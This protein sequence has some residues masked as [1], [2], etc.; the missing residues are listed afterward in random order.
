MAGV[1]LPD[2][3][4]GVAL[5]GQYGGAYLPVATDEAG[6]LYIVLTGS[7]EITIPGDVNV[8]D[9][10][11]LKQI[12]GTDGTTF[13]TAKLNSNGEFIIV[14]RGASGN[15]LAVDA[16]GYMTTVM[17]AIG[18]DANLHTLK[19]DSNGQL[20]MIPRG[21]SGNYMSVDASGYLTAILKGL[22]PDASLGTITVDASG[23]LIMVPRG[24]TGNYMAVDASGFLSSIMKA[25]KGGGALVNVATDANGQLIMVPRGS[26]GNYLYVD[27]VGYLRAVMQGLY[28]ADYR[29]IHTDI[30]GNMI[31]V[32]K[33]TV[34]GHDVTI[35][36]N[37]FLTSVM[38]G[39][40]GATLKTLAVDASGNLV[41]LM[42]GDY[43][44]TLKSVAVDDQGRMISIVMD[45][46]DQWGNV[47]Q[48]GF[49]ELAARL[50]SIVSYDRR[51]QVIFADTFANGFAS[52]SRAGSSGYYITLDPSR[53]LNDGYS[54]KLYPGSVN[55][56]TATLS[57]PLTT[58]PTGTPFGLSAWLFMN[59]YPGSW[60]LW[61]RYSDGATFH[62][63]AIKGVYA[64]GNVYYL[65]AANGL[66]QFTTWKTDILVKEAF[67]FFKLVIN[68]ATH[69]YVRAIIDGNEIDMSALSYYTAAATPKYLILNI[70]VGSDG[71]NN[72]PANVDDV[73]FTTM[74][75]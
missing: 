60:V 68:P 51:G 39:I 1:E 10:N 65:N 18:I 29:S 69:K 16:S 33:D 21:T 44:G 11:T 28:G 49:A 35:D 42:K 30:S 38:K 40:Y 31:A 32:I 41:S 2:W 12:Q 67:R 26:N 71:T 23:Q 61:I 4:R 46:V 53:S 58:F 19:A 62:D 66:T 48:G 74:E 14:P 20:I 24:S 54:V 63:A 17:K 7:P 22:K 13:R 72:G 64:D 25:D 70:Q 34:S 45:D 9:L 36:A 75:P 43:S 8:V 37:G 47:L 5:L 59:P 55:G 27:N 56:Y 57:K 3:L 50:G 52:W 15:Y 6:Q 73:V